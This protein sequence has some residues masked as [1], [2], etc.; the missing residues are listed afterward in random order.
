MPHI[1]PIVRGVW[2]H[3]GRVLLCRNLA[4]G[5]CYLPGGHV[6]F[7]ESG[8]EALRREF[9]EET[10]LM[11]IVRTPPLLAMQ[12][13]FGEGPDLR[14]EWMLVF[15]VEHPPLDPDSDAPPE[16]RSLEPK[17]AFDWVDLAAVVDLDLRP[18]Q[19][20]AWLAA[21]GR[22]DDDARIGWLSAAGE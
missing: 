6:E 21:A 1:A 3:H 18:I 16:V 10:G 5:Y 9:A 12:H 13:V 15:L 7:G 11:P 19:I 17:I 8:E 2:I 4:R 14:H 20:R 22:L